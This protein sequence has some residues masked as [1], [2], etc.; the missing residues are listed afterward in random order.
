[1]KLKELKIHNIASIADA[2]ID[3][4]GG[5]LR[6]EALFL[7]CGETGSGKTTILDSICLVLYNKT[8][9]LSQATARESYLD[10]NGDPLSLSNPVQYLRKG[11]WEASLSLGF[12]AQ[13]KEWEAH[14]S[15]HRANKKADGKFQSVVWE[16]LDRSSGL[17]SKG[18][19]IESIIGLSFDEFR[20]TTMLAQG[21]FTA[22]LKSRDEEKSAILEKIAGTG[23]YRQIGREI[24]ERYRQSNMYCQ[25]LQ[26]AVKGFKDG[27]LDEDKVRQIEERILECRSAVLALEKE[28]KELDAAEKAFVEIE[29]NRAEGIRQ[30]DKLTKAMSECVR[31][32]GGIAYAEQALLAEEESVAALGG[33]I[34]E[35]APHVEMYARSVLLVSQLKGISA[36]QSAVSDLDKEIG[37]YRTTVLSIEKEIADIRN[38]IS[39]REGEI[40]KAEADVAGIREELAAMDPD[41]LRRRKSALETMARLKAD[42]AEK[43]EACMAAGD[44]RNRY[45]SKNDALAREAEE[46]SRIL[47]AT[48]LIYSRMKESNEQWAKDARAGLQVGCECPVCG[49][50]IADQEYLDSISDEHFESVLKPVAEQMEIHRQLAEKAGKALSENQA[51]VKMLQEI[52]NIRSQELDSARKALEE[53]SAEYGDIVYTE[54]EYSG[55]CRVLDKADGLIKVLD[56]KNEAV[57]SMNKALSAVRDRAAALA[58]RLERTAGLM[59]T[60]EQLKMAACERIETSYASVRAGI[61]LEAWEDEWNADREGFCGRLQTEADRYAMAVRE[62]GVKEARVVKIREGLNN[63]QLIYSD[64]VSLL[65]ALV[66]SG[67]GDAVRIERLE[68]SLA[69]VK[70]DVITALSLLKTS[71]DNIAACLEKVEGLDRVAVSDRMSAIGAEITRLNQ[72]SGACART[73]EINKE[74]LKKIGDGISALEKAAIER[75][76]W[77]ALNDVFGKRDGEY[78]QKIAQGFI[79]N[80]ILSRANHHL[81]EMT[82]RY[83]LEAQQGSLN[84]VIRDMEQGGVPRSTSTIS[85]GESFIISLALALGLSSL[86]NGDISADILFIDEGFGSLSD[87]YL[88]TVVE[89]LQ[90]LHERSGRK[91]G[92][93]SHIGHLRNRIATRISVSKINQTTSKVEILG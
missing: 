62:H 52:L 20:R 75:D 3:F 41:G 28:H 15:T 66:E 74:A 50:V 72:E 58:L 32:K 63:I 6:D 11:S 12:E 35:C 51:H 48:A 13:G 77:K 38:E 93:I 70:A 27:L 46:T 78:F 7:I 24:G 82:R 88:N 61:T 1:M 64:I 57:A 39:L 47:E 67:S 91:V 4:D 5:L 54:E 43:E 31:L 76:Q 71:Q 9:R 80:D 14:W 53:A 26:E 16:V 17:T 90:K 34:R 30:H 18:S 59:K 23:I 29:R 85:G 49:Q 44:E 8:P 37:Q 79:M 45:Q 22:F 10:V 55:I 81:K 69:E 60:A 73:L 33:F 56:A 89:T 19:S 36:D 92:I 2:T 42:M 83:R 86:G 68:N 65:P 40:H 87:D 25:T 21:E 84:I